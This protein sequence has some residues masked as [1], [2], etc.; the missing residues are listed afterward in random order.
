MHLMKEEGGSKLRCSDWAW[1]LTLL[2]G[3]GDLACRL[4]MMMMISMVMVAV[5]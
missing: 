4:M 3:P 1:L 2:M 5:G